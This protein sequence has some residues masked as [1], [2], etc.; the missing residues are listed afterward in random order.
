[1]QQ[2][3]SIDV[4]ITSS[5][6]VSRSFYMH[7]FQHT[8][9]ERSLFQ[10]SSSSPCSLM[11]TEV[12][13]M[14]QAVDLTENN[15]CLAV[16]IA[17]VDDHVYMHFPEAETEAGVAA[18]TGNTAP[19]SPFLDKETHGQPEVALLVITQQLQL[20]GPMQEKNVAAHTGQFPVANTQGRV[21]TDTNSDSLLPNASDS[22]AEWATDALSAMQA[23]DSKPS[24]ETGFENRVDGNSSL[25]ICTA[26]S[27]YDQPQSHD[28]EAGSSDESDDTHVY[29]EPYETFY[30]PLNTVSTTDVVATFCCHMR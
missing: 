11:F 10:Y 9:H 5:D 23:S 16:A 4:R 17:Y 14:M 12:S 18:D 8:C 24:N 7:V 25:T 19:Q 22:M 2:S 3:A 20:C 29:C 27:E 1:M 13:C 21:T 30:T 26:T 15:Y 28:T 6:L